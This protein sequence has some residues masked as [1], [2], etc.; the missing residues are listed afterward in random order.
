MNSTTPKRGVK[1]GTPKKPVVDIKRDIDISFAPL[2]DRN[3]G[4]LYIHPKW[5]GMMHSQKKTPK[6]QERFDFLQLVY[7]TYF[8]FEVCKMKRANEIR[9]K[10]IGS[11]RRR[12][13]ALQTDIKREMMLEITPMNEDE[14]EDWAEVQHG[15]FEDCSTEGEQ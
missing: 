7:N 3:E 8:C 11:Y 13:Y 14:F 4:A 10:Y 6:E 9:D 1:M 12:L 2:D 15:D 5:C